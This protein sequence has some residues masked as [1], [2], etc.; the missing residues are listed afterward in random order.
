[1]SDSLHIHQQLPICGGHAPVLATGGAGATVAD[2]EFV[3]ASALAEEESAGTDARTVVLRLSGAADT[4][5]SGP[6]VRWLTAHGRRIVLRT[7]VVLDRETI[8]A[9]Q[10]AGA[11]VLLELCHPLPQLQRALVSPGADSTSSLLLQAQ[12]LRAREI[13]VG[14]HLGPLMPVLHDGPK[15]LDP[16]LAHVASARVSS[17]HLAPGVLSAGR[18]EALDALDRPEQAEALRRAFGLGPHVN[19][20]SPVRLG[21]AEYA[22]LYR[23]ARRAAVRRELEVDRCGCAAHCHLDPMLGLDL[24]RQYRPVAGRELFA[25]HE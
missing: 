9:C 8:T 25:V 5:W 17:V 12:H 3:V 1:M 14:V 11:T 13:P 21:A 16:L 18:L 19:P 22:R 20:T 2:P 23:M 10:E 4:S 24:P 6:A 15:A 7:A